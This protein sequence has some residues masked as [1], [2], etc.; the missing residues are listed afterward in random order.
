M[1][2]L[3]MAAAAACAVACQPDSDKTNPAVA[4]DETKA[5]LQAAAP[6]AGATSFTEDQAQQR[7]I[8]AG[9]SDVTALTKTPDGAWQASA[10]KDGMTVPVTVDYQGNV[11][12]GSSAGGATDAM[13]APTPPPSEPT[14][15]T[16]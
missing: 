14:S 9:Y 1:R 15:P 10:S 12:A 6:A 7:I 11:T 16:P 2:V 4:T 3:L 13:P 8:D 5:E